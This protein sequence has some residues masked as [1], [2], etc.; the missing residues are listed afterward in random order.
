MAANRPQGTVIKGNWSSPK[1][2]RV[3]DSVEIKQKIAELRKSFREFVSFEQPC[4]IPGCEQL[5]LQYREA[6][7]ALGED[8]SDCQ[9]SSINATYQALFVKLQEEAKKL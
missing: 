6:V 3:V 4:E 7:L 8:C 5:R 2:S 1:S 9:I